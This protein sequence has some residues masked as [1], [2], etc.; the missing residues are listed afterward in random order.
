MF[1][2]INRLV[3]L[4]SLSL[5]NNNDKLYDTLWSEE[6][7]DESREISSRISLFVTDIPDTIIL[8]EHQETFL[9]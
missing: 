1:E 3:L 7:D 8:I 6:H 9:A 2:K 4:K 5:K